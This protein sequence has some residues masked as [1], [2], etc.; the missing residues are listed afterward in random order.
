M[1]A[2]VLL[3]AL[4][5]RWWLPAAVWAAGS[6]VISIG[7]YD[8]LLLVPVVWPA[9]FTALTATGAGT[10]QLATLSAASALALRLLPRGQLVRLPP[11][12]DLALAGCTV[13]GAGLAVQLLTDA[14]GLVAQLIATPQVWLAAA[15]CLAAGLARGWRWSLAALLAAG[16]AA[17][18]DPA[19]WMLAPLAATVGPAARLAATLRRPAVGMWTLTGLNTV[20]ATLTAVFVGSGI[21]VEANPLLAGWLWVALPAKVLG[22][23]V[24]AVVLRRFAP[25]L[26]PIPTAALAVVT[27]YHL[28]GAVTV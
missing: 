18:P 6:A 21:A 19:G 28:A 10:L 1:L 2:A 4:T 13:A 7:W 9:E 14:H 25:R 27:V 12:A 20:D 15:A 17:W 22:V 24:A 23:A 8:Q 11:A 5:R 3:A 26:V 16:L